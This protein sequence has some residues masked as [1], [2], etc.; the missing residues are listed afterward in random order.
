MVKLKNKAISFRIFE[1]DYNRYKELAS[2]SGLR[3]T[4]WLVM[5]IERGLKA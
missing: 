5:M 3:L 1:A 2:L 4:D